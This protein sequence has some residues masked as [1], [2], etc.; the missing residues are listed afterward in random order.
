[1]YLP[2]QIRRKCTYGSKSN[3]GKKETTPLSNS[4]KDPYLLCHMALFLIPM[5]NKQHSSA[6]LLSWIQELSINIDAEK[7]GCRITQQVAKSERF[8]N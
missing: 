1:M 7:K 6:Q 5:S 2:W 4:F 3:I 8:C